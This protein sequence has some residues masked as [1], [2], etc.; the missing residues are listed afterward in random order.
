VVHQVL[1]G[2]YDFLGKVGSSRFPLDP[3]WKI[4]KLL[5]DNISQATLLTACSTLQFRLE[6]AVQHIDLFMN[7]VKRV[8]GLEALDSMSSVDSTHS[9]VCSEFSQDISSYEL[10]KLVARPNYHQHVHRREALRIFQSTIPVA[11]KDIHDD[12]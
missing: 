8:L 7:S 10:A 1:E 11:Q 4:L 2:L 6:R 5:E 9:S 3:E 12:Y